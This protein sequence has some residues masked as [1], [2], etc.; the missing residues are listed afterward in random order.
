MTPT[1]PNAVHGEGGA[2]SL[3]FRD[4][5]LLAA[6]GYQVVPVK[7]GEKRP[8]VSKWQEY[9][10]ASADQASHA[11]CGI[12]L[13][14]AR[15]P[16]VDVDV[17]D[18]Q[19]AAE[20]EQMVLEVLGLERPPPR[21]IG[22]APR[23]LLLFRTAEPFKK[24]KT[25]GFRFP[26][27]GPEDKA[28]AVEVLADGQMAIAYHVHPDT[29][30][31]YEWNG[32][33]EPLEIGAA[34][35]P[36]ITA[37][38]A[39]EIIK[40]ATE[41]LAGYGTPVGNTLQAHP[42]EGAQA[43]LLGRKG[44]G[45]A[46][47]GEL[48][49]RDPARLRDA[50]GHVRNAELHYD[51]W[52]H[53]GFAI[54]GALGEEGLTDWLQFSEQSSKF[55]KE[56]T[57]RA[58][59]SF[60]PTSIGAGSIFHWAKA[61]GWVE[62][63]HQEPLEGV[64]GRIV[65]LFAPGD[66]SR[67][68]NEIELALRHDEHTPEIFAHGDSLAYVAVGTPASVRAVQ[69]R[70]ELGEK[71]PEVRLIR[72]HDTHSL[73]RRTSE[74]VQLVKQN[75][76]GS[77]VPIELPVRLAQQVLAGGAS[78]FRPLTGLCEHPLVVDGGRV[79][80]GGGYDRATGLF[81]TSPP[82]L[83]AMAGRPLVEPA[84]AYRW[85][86]EEALAEFPWSEPVDAAGAVAMLL[87]MV[88]RRLMD[89]APGILVTAP[90][91]SSG[92]TAL[93]DLASRLI[94]GR[95]IGA[96]GFATDPNE[97]RKSITAKL[98]EGI[99][100]VLFDNVPAGANLTSDELARAMTSATW[101]D[102]WLGQNKNVELPTSTVWLVTGNNVTA[103]GDFATRMQHIRLDP[104]VE[105]PDR[106]TFKREIASW[107][108]RYRAEAVHCA[109]S[110]IAGYLRSGERLSAAPTRFAQWDRFCRFPVLWASGLDCAELFERNREDDPEAE[111]RAELLAALEAVFG[112]R[113]FSVGRVHGVLRGGGP[114]DS[115]GRRPRLQAAV[116]GVLPDGRADQAKSLGRLLGRIKDL[117]CAGRVLKACGT[118]PGTNTRAWRVVAV[119][120]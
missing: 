92:K 82:E 58:W 115:D 85:L 113:P 43:T 48:R 28:H 33:G 55:D 114:T 65:V 101:H 7:P 61:R 30:R 116:E 53:V 80:A 46:P 4:A 15:T 68:A 60:G 29:K 84:G 97:L 78:K 32:S 10:F 34:E 45:G 110:L 112:D 57:L 106:R 104:R 94:H 52:I 9:Q 76:R 26:S 81:I 11:G 23:V 25:A 62:R 5:G 95:E 17:S 74:T 27:D 73:L 79:V 111:A 91:Q 38:Q 100:A 63:P 89:Q 6:K 41:I 120:G 2:R 77:W 96:S 66:D 36:E 49:A 118:D 20:I 103:V 14:T 67:M 64:P 47:R 31:P 99:P 107:A 83:Q 54:K 40:R 108:E 22:R 12:G 42:T 39:D 37:A 24:R 56:A 90:V 72:R 35:L 50:L 59:D 21:R 105:A 102:R 69:R 98:A 75:A 117:V 51:D 70:H 16:A 88:Q 86:V 13:L 119:E 93:V 71:Y 19:V 8:A 87:L 18:P 109:V 44:G 1:E 3:T